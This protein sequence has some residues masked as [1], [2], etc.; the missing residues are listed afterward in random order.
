MTK[1]DRMTT[2]LP[3]EFRIGEEHREPKTALEIVENFEILVSR[4]RLYRGV[5][6]ATPLAHEC[7]DDTLE[8]TLALR[9]CDALCGGARAC[10]MGT[11]HLSTGQGWH[12]WPGAVQFNVIARELGT[13]LGDAMVALD[14]AAYDY[15]RENGLT[16]HL[17]PSEYAEP[18]GTHTLEELFENPSTTELEDLPE[19]PSQ[20][21][22]DGSKAMSGV[23]LEV[24]RRA[25]ELLER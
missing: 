15:A 12:A 13:P 5:Y 9:E 17:S 4:E 8:F 18:Y 3:A 11:L 7:N 24:A 2:K 14:Q 25:K 23:M 19:T 6:M 20:I 22:D 1:E 10:A 21:D 16:G